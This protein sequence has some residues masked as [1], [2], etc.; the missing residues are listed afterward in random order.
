MNERYIYAL[1]V[2]DGVHWGHQALLEECVALARKL[3]CIPAVV[4]FDVHPE[5][6]VKGKAPVMLS[7]RHDRRSMLEACGIKKVC[8]LH[9]DQKIRSMPW[10]DF[11]NMLT[12]EYHAAGLVCGDDFRFGHKGQGT[13]ALLQQQCARDQIPCV[14]VPEQTMD[15]VRISSTHIRKLIEDGQME[16]AVQF[17][18]HPYIFTGTVVE[19]RKLGR[20]IGVPTAN[21]QLP[22]GVVTPKFGVYACEA[23]IDGRSYMAVTNVGNRPTVGGHRVTVEPWILDFEG[24]LYGKQLQLRFYKF[25]RPEK[26]FPS[27]EDLQEEILKNAEETRKFFENR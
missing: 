8:T 22:E 27:L 7:A 2:F 14:V 18:G 24:D 13:A 15:G 11:Y 3:D 6:L 5:S 25:L 9:F 16:Q 19:G 10:M 1:G 21:L 12:E 23:V 26:K 20:T 17:M 4:T